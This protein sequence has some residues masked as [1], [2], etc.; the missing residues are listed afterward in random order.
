MTRV[1]PLIVEIALHR[2][3]F[4]G[5]DGR[6]K[7]TSISLVDRAKNTKSLE[8]IGASHPPLKPITHVD[9]VLFIFWRVPRGEQTV[10][11]A[12]REPNSRDPI[13]EKHKADRV[14]GDISY[15]D[16]KKS[17][18]ILLLSTRSPPHTLAECSVRLVS[19]L[20]ES[21]SLLWS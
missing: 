5:H 8:A 17:T 20:E 9:T 14:I 10:Q 4:Q 1:Y 7:E 13:V 2:G 18:M 15:T 12:M 3:S 11:L 16:S 21:P 19:S 6:V